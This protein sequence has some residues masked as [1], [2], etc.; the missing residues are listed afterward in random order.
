MKPFC[1]LVWDRN[2]FKVYSFRVEDTARRL[3]SIARRMGYSTAFQ[4]EEMAE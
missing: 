2:T 3:E 1:V 4:G